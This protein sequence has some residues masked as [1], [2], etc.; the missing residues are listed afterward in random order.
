MRWSANEREAWRVDFSSV[1]HSPSSSGEL[2]N[3][4]A[5]LVCV[6]DVSPCPCDVV[7]RAGVSR[8]VGAEAGRA[9]NYLPD[10]IQS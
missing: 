8:S 2:S 10:D 7:P 3:I 1:G 5:L 9:Y 4:A 6:V